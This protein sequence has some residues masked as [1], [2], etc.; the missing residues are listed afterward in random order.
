MQSVVDKVNK[1][2][3]SYKRIVRLTIAKEPMEMTSTK[4]IKRHIVAKQYEN[5][6]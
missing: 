6:E 1:E 2:V 4:K 3:L 5:I